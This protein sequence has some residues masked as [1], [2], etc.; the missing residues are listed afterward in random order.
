M[1]FAPAFWN[2][3]FS[4]R[5]SCALSTF[6]S[7]GR[8]ARGAGG[9]SHNATRQRSSIPT[10]VLGSHTNPAH[11]A[12]SAPPKNNILGASLPEI[13]IRY[14]YLVPLLTPRLSRMT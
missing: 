11:H 1:K 9:D 10:Q 2:G 5:G 4:W 7:P 8:A 14:S 12:S 13:Q 6:H 3:N